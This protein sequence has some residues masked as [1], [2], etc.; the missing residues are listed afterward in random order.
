MRI[1]RT[2]TENTKL[3]ETS[4]KYGVK[5]NFTSNVNINVLPI[6]AI[7]RFILILSMGALFYTYWYIIIFNTVVPCDSLGVIYEA[8]IP[9]G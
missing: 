7:F 6:A 8:V 9:F 4:L 2:N 3:V 1:F 5:D